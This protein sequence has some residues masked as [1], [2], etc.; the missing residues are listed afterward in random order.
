VPDPTETPWD[1][2]EA[3]ARDVARRLVEHGASEEFTWKV[4]DAISAGGARGAYAIDTAARLL[5]RLIPIL[6]SPRR[7]DGVGT[8][9]YAFVGP[10]GVGKTTAYV[11]LARHLRASDRRVVVAGLDPLGIGVHAGI[12]SLPADRDRTELAVQNVRDSLELRRLA[13]RNDPCDAILL[14]TPGVS[15]RDVQAIERLQEELRTVG[16]RVDPRVLL[17]LS[18][19]ASRGA[20]EMALEAF[21]RTRP[22]GA[23][24]TCLDETDEPGIVLEALARRRLPVAL[25]SDRQDLRGE[26]R[27]PRPDDFADLMLRGRLA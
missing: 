20:I 24:V 17:V 2:L 22:V 4:V 14:D 1:H 25:L 18:A 13:R 6:R 27:R 15:P 23:V 19:T 5:G 26:P 8:P 12:G 11:R 3:G 10:A 21:E 7:G 9:L 16:H